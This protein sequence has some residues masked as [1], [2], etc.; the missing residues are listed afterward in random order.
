MA[1]SRILEPHQPAAAPSPEAR[2]E[3]V[4]VPRRPAYA[5]FRLLQV[6]FVVAPI[7]AGADK[8]FHVL[9]NWDMYLAS[10]IERQLPVSGHTFMQIVGVIE[11]VAGFLVAVAP[12][13]G[14]FIVSAWLC[15][16]IVDL[17]L[18]GG[19]YDIAL[20][21]LGLAF[22]ACALGLLAREFGRPADRR[23]PARA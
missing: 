8:F 22:G 5:A 11:I 2:V 21:D 9:T 20:R 13:I 16:I 19:F 23:E 3:P 4:R 12:R 15:G 1:G 7:L 18:A 17:L 10:S 14:G 6:G